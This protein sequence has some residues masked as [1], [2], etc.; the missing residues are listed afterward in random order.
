MEQTAPYSPNHLLTIMQK[1]SRCATSPP[2]M[3]LS[4]LRLCVLTAGKGGKGGSPGGKGKGGGKGGGGKGGRE[5]R[6]GEA[7]RKARVWQGCQ[8]K[9]SELQVTANTCTVAED[10]LITGPVPGRRSVW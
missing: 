5:A 6:K 1:N 2:Y 9:Q 4:A 3:S 10:V 7:G 8:G